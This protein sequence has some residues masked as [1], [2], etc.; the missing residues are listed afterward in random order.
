MLVRKV[1][2]RSFSG[3]FRNSSANSADKNKRDSVKEGHF[4]LKK[5]D[6]ALLA[7]CECE[8]ER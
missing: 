4:I 5:K 3:H 7:L 1:A 8:I 6:V 2:R